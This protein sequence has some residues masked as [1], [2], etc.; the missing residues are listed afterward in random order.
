MH[1]IQLDKDNL[2]K[3][4]LGQV[5][6]RENFMH[7]MEIMLKRENFM[8]YM[9]LGTDLICNWCKEMLGQDVISG[10]MFSRYWCKSL[11]RKPR[12]NKMVTKCKNTSN[13]PAFHE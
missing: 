8:H 2:C 6:K 4:M 5:L 3:E 11:I 1:D 9:A 7:Y 12:H 13:L 10:S